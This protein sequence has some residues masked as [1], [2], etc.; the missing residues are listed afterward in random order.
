MLIAVTRGFT[1]EAL[2]LAAWVLALF[3]TL[4]GHP[5][6]YPYVVEIVQPDQMASLITYAAL[7]IG[8]LI[9]FKFLGS[10]IGKTVKESHIG[11]LDRGLGIL[12]GIVRGMFIVS[13]AYLLTTPFFSR[14]EYPDSFMEAKSRP[15]I[16]YGA[17]M[18]NS[19]NPYK[20]E[21]LFGED[22]I[23]TD[24]FGTFKNIVPSFPA[25]NDANGEETRYDDETREE[26]NNL[27]EEGT[28]T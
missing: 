14:D 17:S 6:A 2:G 9:L 8:S 10:V 23:G 7:G 25:G 22:S 11:A 5:I 24:W 1:T 18:L 13:F 4:Q 16:E 12:F 26:M 21:P 28:K 3:V 20:S 19:M 27:F 15:L